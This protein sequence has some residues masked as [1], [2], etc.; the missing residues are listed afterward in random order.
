M[1]SGILK[2]LF[3]SFVVAEL[4]QV[5]AFGIL[6]DFPYMWVHA[7]KSVGWALLAERLSTA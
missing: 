3:L 2:P 6:G 4:Y 7:C 5:L 1:L